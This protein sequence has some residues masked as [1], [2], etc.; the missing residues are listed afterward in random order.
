M[1]RLLPLL[2]VV[3]A[4][5]GTAETPTAPP[6]ITEPTPVELATLPE[7]GT[8]P[9]EFQPTPVPGLPEFPPET[10]TTAELH[11]RL[12]PFTEG[13]CQ[14]PCYGGLVPGEADTSDALAFYSQLGIGTDDLIPG[15]YEDILDGQG[16][17]RAWL[18]R[19]SDFLSSE[20]NLDPPLVDVYIEENAVRYMLVGWQY[21]PPYLTVSQVLDQR[22]TPNDVRAL[23]TPGEEDTQVY[24]LALLYPTE[25]GQ[26]LA[27]IYEGALNGTEVCFTEEA[28]DLTYLGTYAPAQEPLTGLAA[29]EGLRSLDAVAGI[30]PADFAAQVGGGACL[31]LTPEQVT[32][33]EEEE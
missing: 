13:L 8:I 24:T 31:T 22:G 5:C 17:M 11:E 29:T 32:A 12:D 6:P 16:N 33:L 4:A 1:K 18:T 2:A 23:I 7:F 21:E 3:L 28:I 9:P 30:P 20:L 25:G 26:T 27:F 14:L 15:D 19:T 10:L